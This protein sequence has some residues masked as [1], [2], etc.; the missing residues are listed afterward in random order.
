MT[1]MIPGDIG[2]CWEFMDPGSKTRVKA[3]SV[4]SNNGPV[5]NVNRVIIS[6]KKDIPPSFSNMH[7]K[8][9]DPKKDKKCTV[10]VGDTFYKFCDPKKDKKCKVNFGELLLQSITK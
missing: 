4:G 1:S 3:C 6:S 2:S 9:C 10:E 7:V 8:K 5:E